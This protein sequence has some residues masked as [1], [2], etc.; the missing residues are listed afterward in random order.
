MLEMNIYIFNLYYSNHKSM[1]FYSASDF[2]FVLNWL[3]MGLF[4]MPLMEIYS[5]Q[6]IA[7]L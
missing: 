7:A 6:Q 2:P 3:L 5:L 1:G 4:I